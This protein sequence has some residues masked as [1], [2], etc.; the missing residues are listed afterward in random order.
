M[1]QEQTERTRG[2]AFEDVIYG[3]ESEVDSEDEQEKGNFQPQRPLKS[4]LKKLNSSAR[5]RADG[6]DPMDLLEGVG[7]HGLTC[8]YS[9]PLTH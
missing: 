6:D 9:Y 8:E 4:A 1:S 3:S 7:G 5:L 2:D